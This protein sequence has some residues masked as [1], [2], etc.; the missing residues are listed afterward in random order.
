MPRGLN[1]LM[2]AGDVDISLINADNGVVIR[3]T[4]EKPEVVQTL[5]QEMPQW[6][7]R[8]QEAGAQVRQLGERARRRREAMELLAS[9][10][11][12]LEVKET[13]NGITVNV[14]SEDPEV[15][16]QIKERLVEYFKNQKEL[17]RRAEER[18]NRPAGQA[19]G[20]MG[21]GAGER[22]RRRVREAEGDQP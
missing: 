21:P 1:G 9:D 13:E 5:Q 10:Q 16:K 7:G 11:V 3:F 6:V 17:A 8:A 22:L 19:G 2:A 12:A 4:S 20:P 18:A 14:T 15:I